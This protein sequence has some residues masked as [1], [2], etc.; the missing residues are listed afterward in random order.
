[1]IMMVRVILL[2]LALVTVDIVPQIALAA[3]PERSAQ[4]PETPAGRLE[5]ILRRGTLI[6]G[7]KDD[8]PPMGFRDGNEGA[9][10]GFEPD[11]AQAVADRLGVAL[12]LVPVTSSN[13]LG[14]V[15]QGQIDL[16][17]ATMGDTAERRGQAG[18]IQPNYYASGVALYGRPN[19]PYS[20]WGQLRGRPVCLVRGGYY[21][22]ILDDTYLVSGQY[23]PSPRDA[24]LALRQDACVGW[25]FDDV[26]LVSLAAENET[27]DFAVSLPSILTTPWALAVAKGEEN[28]DWGRFVSDLVAEWHARGTFLEL[29]DKWGLYPSAYL[30]VAQEIWSRHEGGEY[31]CTR[32]LVTGEFR[33]TCVTTDVLRT[34]APPVDVPAWAAT[35]QTATGWDL[36]VVFEAYDRARLA[37]GLGQTLGL[38]LCAILGALV[39]GIS[40][41]L[42]NARLMQS[43]GMARLLRAP[44]VGVITLARMTPPILQLY[45]VFFGLGGLMST[46]GHATPGAFITAT[47][48]FSFYAGA[49]NAVLITHGLTQERDAH[50]GIGLFQALPQAL[51]RS[52][53]GLVSTCVN[54]VKAAGMASAIAVTE[55]IATVNL[56][57]TEGGDAS[58][59]MNGLLVFYFFFVMAVLWLFR[60]IKS[61]FLHR[62]SRP[63]DSHELGA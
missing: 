46:A 60:W 22:R 24:L 26:A 34:G 15:N 57:I 6:V 58:V 39:I 29:Q 4:L 25:A 28:A 33:Q 40:L 43:R 37:R 3:G 14:R 20:D 5:H 44:V 31:Y 19:L 47:L 53:D 30:S 7:V 59:L 18:L 56:I 11:M 50:P 32:D 55:L 49:T 35:L 62:P 21:N 41:G 1:M 36:S 27:S 42:M 52:Y 38:S 63:L 9:I 61:A 8:Y 51:V 45:I 10:I 48:I 54:I 16:V 13:R 2:L 17:I 12:E 23:Y